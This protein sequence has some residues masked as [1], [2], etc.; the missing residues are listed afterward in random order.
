VQ[1][2]RRVFALNVLTCPHCGGPQH[3]I[4]RLTDPVVVRKFLAPLGLP[5]EPQRRAPGLVSGRSHEQFRLCL[6]RCPCPA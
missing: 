5:T 2:L 1:L 4:G 6:S 3:L